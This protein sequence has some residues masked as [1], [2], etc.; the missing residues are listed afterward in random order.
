M[1]FMAIEILAAAFATGI[2]V[3]LVDEIEDGKDKT[4]KK[5][6]GAAALLGIFYGFLMAYVMI[7]SALVANL[8]M[9]AVLA[10]VLAGKIDAAGHRLGV[11]SMLLILS[12]TGFPKFEAGLLAFFALAAF[13]DEFLE[14]LA[15]KRKIRGRIASKMAQLR[16]VLEISALAASIYL[17]Q[18]MLFASILLF[19]TGYVLASVKKH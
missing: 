19:D 14:G 17:N 16:A 12:I 3:K 15:E 8:W 5:S 9:A 2:V 11:F 18:W 13:S 6:G 1:I 7:K 4:R 10:N